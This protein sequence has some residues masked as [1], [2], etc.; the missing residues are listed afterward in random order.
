MN[1]GYAQHGMGVLK[2]GFGSY[3]LLNHFE[4][5]N[6]FLCIYFFKFFVECIQDLYSLRLCVMAGG[7]KDKRGKK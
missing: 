1:S 5:Y 6:L 7:M 3:C 4:M 2:A